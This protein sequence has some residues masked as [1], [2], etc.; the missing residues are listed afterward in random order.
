EGISRED[1][2]RLRSDPSYRH[3]VEDTLR[4]YL[5]ESEMGRVT[6]LLDRMASAETYEQAQ[7][8]GRRPVLDAIH[9][10]EGYV[11]TDMNHVYDA[12]LHMR[13]EEQA[14]YRDDAAFR[15]QVDQ[16]V[17]QAVLRSA[18]NLEV[19]M[20][21][22]QARLETATRMLR[23]IEAGQQPTEDIIF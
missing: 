16:A 17:Q 6:T 11:N 5:D 14:R 2:Q 23:Q 4:T 20:P 21:D 10:A 12:I 15:Q 13:P 1:W 3:E 7:S 18:N 22:Y 19:G 9:D 8:A